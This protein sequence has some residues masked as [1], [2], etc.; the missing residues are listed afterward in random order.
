M[1]FNIN[2]TH[3]SPERRK[4]MMRPVDAVF[5]AEKTDVSVF[6]TIYLSMHLAAPSSYLFA[7]NIVYE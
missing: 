6:F 5:A 3:N 7:D 4:L 2:H 1:I